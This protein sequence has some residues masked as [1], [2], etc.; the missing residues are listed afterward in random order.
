MLNKIIQGEAGEVTVYRIQDKDGRGPWKPGFSHRWV[1]DREDHDNLVPWPMEFGPVH[2]KI[3]TWESAGSGCQTI[4]QLRRWFTK[5]EYETLLSHGYRAV[6]MEVSRILAASDIQ[7]VF[8]RSNKPLNCDFEVV[9][10]YENGA[11]IFHMDH[12]AP[13]LER[14]DVEVE[15]ADKGNAFREIWGEKE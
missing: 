12:P 5:S 11:K 1:E 9:S 6:K 7:C 14:S 8:T 3:F 10:L 4:E 2:K 13:V 15:E